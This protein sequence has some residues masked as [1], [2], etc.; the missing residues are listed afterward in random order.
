MFNH[1]QRGPVRG[2][3]ITGSSVHYQRIERLWRDLF[4]CC[5]YIYYSIFYYLEETGYLEFNNS[6]VLLA[7]HLSAKDKQASS[8]F[9]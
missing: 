2:S 8:T 7:L 5:L 6:H 1:P 3:Y 4:V 9:Q